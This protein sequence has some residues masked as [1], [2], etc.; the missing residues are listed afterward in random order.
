MATP[1]ELFI[2]IESMVATVVLSLLKLN[3][4][5]VIARPY[6]SNAWALKCVDWP[7]AI[8]VDVGEIVTVMTW[9]GQLPKGMPFTRRPGENARSSAAVKCC[10]NAPV[11]SG[12]RVRD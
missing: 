7:A 3:V 5:F 6:S 8:S 1:V 11:I 12:Q 9:P 4:T 10:T 2:V